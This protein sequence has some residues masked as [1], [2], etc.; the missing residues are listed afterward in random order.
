MY[1]CLY[2]FSSECASMLTVKYMIY[3]HVF[4]LYASVYVDMYASLDIADSC[5]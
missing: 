5:I 4:Q 2:V 1:I 3:T